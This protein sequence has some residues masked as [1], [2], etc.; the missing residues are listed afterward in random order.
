MLAAGALGFCGNEIVAQYRIRVG[1]RIGS[2]AL[3]AD[4]MHA[5]T[6]GLTSLGVVAATIGVLL[7]F[8]R[9]DALVGLAITVAIVFT[10]WERPRPCSTEPS[11]APTRAPWR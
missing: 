7:G 9:A 2:A 1:Q 6:D 4:G 11:T 3:V 10:M 5:R 8:E